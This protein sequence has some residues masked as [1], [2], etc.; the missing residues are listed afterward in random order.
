MQKPFVSS[1]NAF[2]VA[3]PSTVWANASK[4]L[5]GLQTADFQ[6][7]QV[8]SWDDFPMNR[9][10][11]VADSGRVLG[12]GHHAKSMGR[13]GERIARITLPFYGS[14][15]DLKAEVDSQI[16]KIDRKIKTELRVV[17]AA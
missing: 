7:H 3:R 10:G 15:R 2:L 5:R 12:V 13:K 11:W 4:E 8:R 9:Y 16:A 14:G 6:Q 1:T 17:R